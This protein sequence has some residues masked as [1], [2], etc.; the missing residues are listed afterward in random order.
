[1]K[2]SYATIARRIRRA[3][4]EPAAPESGPFR[5]GYRIR[6]LLAAYRHSTGHEAEG[7]KAAGN[8]RRADRARCGPH[9][10]I[11]PRYSR[12]VVAPRPRAAR[13]R[14]L[15]DRVDELLVRSKTPGR[16]QKTGGGLARPALPCRV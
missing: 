10:G 13:N 2:N 12:L 15:R 6:R 1:V 8:H 16:L 11:S 7:I 9:I 4:D 3:N 14:L 5:F